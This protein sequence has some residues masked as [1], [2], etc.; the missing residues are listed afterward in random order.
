VLAL[1]ALVLVF[2]GAMKSLT[3]A[4]GIDPR[5]VALVNSATQ[6]PIMNLSMI[7]ML[8]LIAVNAPAK[9]RALW[10]SLMASFMNVALSA[11]DLMT[12][13]MN[14]IFVV[15]RGS[16]GALPALTVWALVISFVLPVVAILL[17]RKRVE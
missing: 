16:Y 11:G 10:F 4:T 8:A 17:W 9:W 13:Y 7:P 12:K 1:P 3:A 2:E 6:S 14:Q 15:E 5:S